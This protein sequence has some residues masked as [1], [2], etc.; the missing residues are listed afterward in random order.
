MVS[1]RYAR[2]GVLMVGLGAGGLG[3]WT[4]VGERDGDAVPPAPMTAFREAMVSFD[5]LFMAGVLYD[6]FDAIHGNFPNRIILYSDRNAAAF[7][8]DDRIRVSWI[9]NQLRYDWLDVTQ[10]PVHL[11]TLDG[12]AAGFMAEMR[13][14]FPH[15]ILETGQ[16]PTPLGVTDYNPRSPNE[17]VIV[18]FTD[19]QTWAKDLVFVLEINRQHS[20]VREIWFTGPGAPRQRGGRPYR[21]HIDEISIDVPLPTIDRPPGPSSWL[22]PQRPP[23]ALYLPEWSLLSR[24]KDEFLPPHWRA[25]TPSTRFLDYTSARDFVANRD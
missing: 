22:R 19:D 6:D 8:I 17:W 12:R 16:D 5:T 20:L 18:R 14:G 3:F 15:A 10:G 11:P 24:P 25:T 1:A 21:L 4:A 9:E 23:H 13:H 7:D 2:W